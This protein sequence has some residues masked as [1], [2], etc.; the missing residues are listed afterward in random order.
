MK[1]IFSDP[2]IRL[3]ILAGLSTAAVV[4]TRP[5]ALIALLVLAALMTAAGGAGFGAIRNGMR[6]FFGLVVSLFILQCLFSRGGDP[7][8]IIGGLTVVT[9]SGLTAAV[10][11][12]LRLLIIMFGAAVMQG[13]EARDRLLALTEC[14]V[15]Y[16]IA[17]AVQ[18]AARFLP[19][20]REEAGDVLSAAELRGLKVKKAGLKKKAAAY[21]GL[22]L[23]VTAGAVRRAE[24]MSVAMEARAFGALPRRTSMRRLRFQ[25]SDI[26][27]AALFC[28]ALSA[29]IIFLN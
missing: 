7:V 15:P 6:G 14:K 8:L 28:A 27:S 19:G 5:A 1:P 3:L 16:E 22:L 24:Q 21:A 2:R 29:I 25:A 9:E 13:G 26:I 10:S 11:V 23:P 12:S 20:L 4:L 18:A 17:F